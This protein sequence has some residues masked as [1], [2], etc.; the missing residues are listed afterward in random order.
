M[1][2]FEKKFITKNCKEALGISPQLSC[3]QMVASWLA[4]VGGEV[5]GRRHAESSGH[6]DINNKRGELTFY[7]RKGRKTKVYCYLDVL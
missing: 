5:Q 3:E 7:P 1:R 6:M 2:S 4:S